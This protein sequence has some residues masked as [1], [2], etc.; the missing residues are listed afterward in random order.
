[1]SLFDMFYRDTIKS[2]THAVSS[3]GTVDEFENLTSRIS[4]WALKEHNEDGTHNFNL[5][6]NLV[7]IGAITM[8]GGSAAPSNWLLCDGSQVSRTTYQALFNIIGTTYGIGDGSTTFNLP[9]L[10]QRF[11]LGKASAGT[12][13]TLGSTGGAIDH[14][15]SIA[16]LS[17]PGLSIPALSV[18]ALSVNLSTSSNGAH[19]HT[20]ATGSESND[21]QTFALQTWDLN[22]ANRTQLNAFLGETGAGGYTHNHTIS[23]DG[24]HTHTVSGNTGTGSTGTGTTGTGTSGPGT[25]GTNNPPYLVINYIILSGV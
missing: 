10:R 5:N 16:G 12:G 2:P 19:T 22:P 20:G 13:A 4:A 3:S 21:S 7:P 25:S 15:H 18:P 6:G 9:D 24:A 8:W 17:I 1:M 23:S 14:N 11:P